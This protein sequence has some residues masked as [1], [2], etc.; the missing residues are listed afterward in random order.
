MSEIQ[1]EQLRVNEVINEIDRK[2]AS[3]I[4]KTMQVGSQ[5]QEIKKEFWDD[6]TMN[7]DEPDDIVE[8]FTSI[9]QQ[10]ELLAERERRKGLLDRQLLT[11]TKLRNTPYFGRI[12]FQEE[13]ESE[14]EPI[15]I[16]IASLMD[17]EDENFLIY[18]WRA[19]ISSLY[20]DYSPGSAEY[21]TPS[22][23][24][25]GD[26]R[27]K[28]QFIIKNGVI[29]GMFDT[30][31]TIGD[32]LLQEVLGNQ[33]NTQMK[34][35]VA[36]IQKEQNEIIRNERDKIVVVQG[37]AGSGKTSAALQRAAFLLYRYRETLH[38]DNIML[39]SPNPL[40][41]S[42][43]S[44]VLPELGEENMEQ[45]TFQ[46]YLNSRLAGEFDVE[47]PF[48]QMEFLLTTKDDHAFNVRRANI[49]YKS[50]LDYKKMIDD[51]LLSLSNEGLVFTDIVFRGNAIIQNKDIYKQFYSMDPSITIPNRIQLIQ[52]WLLGEIRRHEKLERSKLWVENEIELLDKE[53]FLEV[54]KEMQ[55]K[56]G[57]D[58]SFD[59]FDLEKRFL[60]KKVVSQ[61]FKPIKRKIKRFQFIN[62]K[63]IFINLFMKEQP[64]E[65]RSII[66]E[67]T[68]QNMIEGKMAYEDATPYLYLTDHIG[69][70]KSNTAIRHIF[71][72]EAQDYSSFQFAFIQEL[73]P[74]SKMTLLGDLNQAIY[75]HSLSKLAIYENENIK[76]YKLMRSYRSTREIVEF[77]KDLI[78]DGEKIESFNREGEKPKVVECANQETFIQ[79]M[80]HE[81]IDAQ[82][83]GNQTIAIICKTAEESREAYN[84]LNQQIQ[85]LKLI[86]KNALSYESG[87]LIIPSYLAKGI[88]FDAV[89]IYDSSGYEKEYERKLFYTACTRPMHRLTIFSKGELSPFIKSISPTSYTSL[90]R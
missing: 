11:F 68:L 31:L 19:P 1:N 69:G 34:S 84:E 47:D 26:M 66:A 64:N 16:G 67:F 5:V 54:Y 83:Q 65:C 14:L 80:L 70:K 52:E 79:S 42:Y 6:V 77:T 25:Q 89:I 90:K 22:G 71:I 59:D 48:D 29:G 15:Y 40:F 60:S 30:G 10:A 35:I 82:T 45:T 7:L 4:N 73:Y 53:D 57:D 72:D 8:T 17:N 46:Q 24:I 49:E 13:E 61:R 87:V 28:R 12:D 51:Y 43:V 18:D 9:K 63:E 56:K 44:T 58:D 76:N 41:N 32:Q 39:F 85:D 86:E 37:V 38:S 81:I 33:A 21:L 55:K 78:A 75:L 74:Y 88:E 23:L 50:S 2:T 20:Y 62:I 27:L 36:T 3:Y